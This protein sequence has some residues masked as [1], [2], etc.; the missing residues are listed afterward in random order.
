MNDDFE[1]FQ[2][3]RHLVVRGRDLVGAIEALAHPGSFNVLASC[4][5]RRMRED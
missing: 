5:G 1:G 2:R 4:V 3:G